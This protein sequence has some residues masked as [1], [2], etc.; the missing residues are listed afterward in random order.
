MRRCIC[1]LKVGSESYFCRPGLEPGPIHRGSS[2]RTQALKTFLNNKSRGVW[3]PAF[4]GTTKWIPACAL[5]LAERVA[6][7]LRHLQQRRI[8]L[9]QPLGAVQSRHHGGGELAALAQRNETVEDRL[10]V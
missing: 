1:S 6:Q 4:A 10:L 3:V 9:H 7:L 5:A 8:V 2:A